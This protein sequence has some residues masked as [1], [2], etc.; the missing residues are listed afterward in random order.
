MYY[1]DDGCIVVGEMEETAT[2]AGAMELL[3]DDGACLGDARATA[4]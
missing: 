3:D 1:D 2:V 4:G